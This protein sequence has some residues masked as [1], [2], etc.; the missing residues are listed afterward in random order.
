VVTAGDLTVDLVRRL[1][2]RA[3]VA[4]RLSPREYDLL[5]QLVG[6]G[7]KVVSHRQLLTAVWGPAHEQDIQYLRVFVGQL[8][9]KIEPDPA[10]PTLILTEPGVGYRW[11]G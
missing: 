9:Q 3:G 2:T 5:A 1:V 10:S 7:G 11:I 4:V 8:R 6:G